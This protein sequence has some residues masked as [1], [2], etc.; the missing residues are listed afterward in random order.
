MPSIGSNN[1]LNPLWHCINKCQNPH[2]RNVISF[3][4]NSHHHFIFS[5]N[6]RTPGI[7]PILKNAP[8]VL[9]RVQIRRAG[10]P[11]Q[12]GYLIPTVNRLGIS[13]PVSGGPIL[14]N[15]ELLPGILALPVPERPEYRGQHMGTITFCSYCAPIITLPKD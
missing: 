2:L 12:L 14:H 7:E 1:C 15:P 8:H 5:G 4:M 6:S 10:G 13:C 9:D 3:L 11:L